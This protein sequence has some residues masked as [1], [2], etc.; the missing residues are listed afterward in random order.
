LARGDR[1]PAMSNEEQLQ[2][3]LVRAFVNGQV[4]GA[5]APVDHLSI[6]LSHVFLSGASGLS[7]PSRAKG[8]WCEV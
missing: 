5:S 4:S 6:H 2:E 7:T 3:D 8:V 1:E